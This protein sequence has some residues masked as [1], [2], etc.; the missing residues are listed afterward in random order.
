MLNSCSKESNSDIFSC[1][2]ITNQ[3]VKDNLKQVQ[4]FDYIKIC[5][6]PVESQK[7]V[8]RASTPEKRLSIMKEKLNAV[9]QL[10]WSSAEK[11]HIQ[12]LLNFLR[13]SDFSEPKT[14]EIIN[15]HKERDAFFKT[16]LF[17][18][19]NHFGWTLKLIQS[20][21]FVL[22][23]RTINGKLAEYSNASQTDEIIPGKKDCE[24]S[25][26]S[27]FCGPEPL[28]YCKWTLNCDKSQVGCG[29]LWTYGCNGECTLGSPDGIIDS[30]PQ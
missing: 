13:V 17:Y 24:C 5:Q 11:Q 20:M 2:P 4:S 29:F 14:I 30:K 10:K 19:T 23:T 3:W 9:Y 1:D 26:Q 28:G 16:W 7:A 18:G 25:T 8:F 22:S 15:E 6:L 21:T 12:M 27:D